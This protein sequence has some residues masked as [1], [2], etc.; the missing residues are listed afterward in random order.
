MRHHGWEI[1]A[2]MTQPTPSGFPA[3]LTW[4]QVSDVFGQEPER[5]RRL[6]APEFD[7]PTQ[8]TIGDAEGPGPVFPMIRGQLS[9]QGRL[10]AG[11]VRLD[12]LWSLAFETK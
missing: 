8:K 4:Y 7:V 6:F 9:K 5:N 3:F 12:S 1:W 10:F 11:K 2:A